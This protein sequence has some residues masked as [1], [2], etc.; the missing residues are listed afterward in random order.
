ML[1]NNIITEIPEKSKIR[2]K[3]NQRRKGVLHIK[4]DNLKKIE[5]ISSSKSSS[6]SADST[7]IH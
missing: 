4:V 1:D 5:Q 3:K 6:E 7:E 2:N